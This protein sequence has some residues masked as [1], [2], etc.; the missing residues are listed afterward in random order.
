[1]PVIAG[2]IKSIFTGHRHADA[3][4]SQDTRIRGTDDPGAI[5]AMSNSAIDS[6]I[7]R[8]ITAT[9]YSTR[10]KRM[11]AMEDRLS[12]LA[13]APDLDPSGSLRLTAWAAKVTPDLSFTNAHIL[14]ES[15]GLGAGFADGAYQLDRD[16]FRV[17]LSARQGRGIPDHVQLRD[18]QHDRRA[19][20]CRQWFLLRSSV[21]AAIKAPADDSKHQLRRAAKH[22]HRDFH[23]GALRLAFVYGLYCR[24]QFRLRAADRGAIHIT[25]SAPNSIAAVGTLPDKM[26][27]AL[28]GVY[29]QV[30]A[31]ENSMT[32]YRNDVSG[33][34]PMDL[35]TPTRLRRRQT[36]TLTTDIIGRRRSRTP[37]RR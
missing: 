13:S 17:S 25:V 16:R 30:V 24:C 19:R 14:D 31:A 11:A 33:I 23:A 7:L 21:E 3:N 2:Q 37:C 32:L 22:D 5:D 4:P 26:Q 29:P 10:L 35:A 8:S 6:S 34:P 28:E 15:P 12:T 36:L 20:R 27:G 18:Q 9:R 1:M